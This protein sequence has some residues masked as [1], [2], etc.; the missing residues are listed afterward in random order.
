[1]ARRIEGTIYKITYTALWHDF[2]E[3]SSKEDLFKYVAK[4]IINGQVVTS[5]NEMCK[6]GSTPKVKIH[7]DK[8]FKKILKQYQNP[9]VII[10]KEVYW[11]N[12]AGCHY[13]LTPINEIDK[14]IVSQFWR[15]TTSL[16]RARSEANEWIKRNE[17]NG[18]KIVIEKR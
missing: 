8:D 2:V 14:Q 7:T 11:T 18:I 17:E 4:E 13:G 1:M 10:V 15:D 3:C 12:R 5:V 6:D 9:P 16:K